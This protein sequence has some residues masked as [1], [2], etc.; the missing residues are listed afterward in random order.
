MGKYFSPQEQFNTNQTL[1][2]YSLFKKYPRNRYITQFWYR[3]P[4]AEHKTVSDMTLID[5]YNLKPN[6]EAK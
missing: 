6:M 2:W 3:L 4:S 5:N 1:H